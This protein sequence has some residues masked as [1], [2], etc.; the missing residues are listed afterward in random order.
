MR[1]RSTIHATET[2]TVPVPVIQRAVA[3]FYGVTLNDIMAMR[4]G[5]VEVR[6]RWV[7]M[8]LTKELTRLSIPNIGRAFDRDHTTIIHAFNRIAEARGKDWSLEAEI[9]AIRQM[10]MRPAQLVL[11][12]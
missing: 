9:S 10:L 2:L 6:A 4:R 7:A 5:P 8:L 1:R 3:D 11:V 12:A